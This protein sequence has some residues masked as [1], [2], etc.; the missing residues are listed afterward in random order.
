MDSKIGLTILQWNAN[1]IRSRTAEFRR[2]LSSTS[3]RPDIICL[4]ETNLKSDQHWRLTGY[5]LVRKDSNSLKGGVAIYIHNSISYTILKT[6]DNICNTGISIRCN[7]T[8]LNI[9][10]IYNPPGTK[11]DKTDYNSLFNLP[12]LLVLGDFNAWSPLWGSSTTNKAGSIFEEVIDYCDM[13][14]LNTGQ[15]T[16]THH[17][18]NET[19]IDIS[20]A[21]KS[22]AL[23]CDWKVLSDSLGSDHRPI[24]VSVDQKVY[25]DEVT[26]ERFNIRKADWRKFE[27]LSGE[28]LTDECCDDNTDIFYRN[29]TSA[30]IDSASASI[31]ISKATHRPRSVQ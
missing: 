26:H 11:I 22:L 30:I 3:N 7:G 4:Q 28:K 25:R 20:F 18:G 21:S 31:P 12:N 23:R 27:S 2:Y 5:N 29:I 19:V 6:N 10:T 9:I 16:Y 8:D 15:T 17:N 1:G 14:V 13:A 24:L